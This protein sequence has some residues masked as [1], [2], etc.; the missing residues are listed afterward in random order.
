MSSVSTWIGTIIDFRMDVL[1]FAK[2]YM[3]I[4]YIK[5]IEDPD[6]VPEEEILGIVNGDAEG[7]AITF[8]S[9]SATVSIVEDATMEGNHVY[10]FTGNGSGKGWTY[11]V[12]KYPFE[13]GKKY[14]ISFDARGV[15]DSKGNK[16]DMR[17]LVNIQ[18]PS[19]SGET[20][21]AGNFILPA[22]GSWVHRET[23]YTV[24]SMTELDKAFFS[25]YIDPPSEDTSGTFQLDNVVVE[26]IVEIVNGDAEGEA[27][28][29]TSPSATVS[30]VEDATMDGNHVYQF[31]GNG[32][33]KGWTYAVHKYPF[34]TGKRYKIS[35]DARGVSD[36][37]GNKVDMR[38]LVNIQYPSNSGETHYAGN[39]I[40]PEDGSWV[41]HET[42]YTVESMTELDKAFFSCYI[43]PPSEDTSGT[44]QLDNVVVEEIVEIVNGDAEGEAIYFTSPSATVSIVEDATMDGNHVYQFTGNGSGK[45]WTYAVHKYPFE[46]GKRYKISF[47]ARGVSDSKGN[48]VD[49]RLLVNIQYPSNSGETHYAGNLILPADGSWVH[50]ETVYTMESIFGIEE[51]FFSCYIDPPSEDTSGTFQLDNVVVEEVK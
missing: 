3:D 39:F 17:L 48:K 16:V 13:T 14:K 47:D 29:F 5:F 50:H 41:H 4:D 6:Y 34:E 25:C 40:L 51:T 24:E 31:T 2:G 11:A 8:T 7:E 15:S 30:I 23:I 46:T 18:Y 42:I 1:S 37:K 35:F 43:D 22:D 20:H 32:S 12:H 45:G 21:Y 19:N 44:F 9:P 49:M 33:G 38:L 27:I 28:Y 36:S 26:E 10:Q